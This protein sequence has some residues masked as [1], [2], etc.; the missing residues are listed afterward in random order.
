[1]TGSRRNEIELSSNLEKMLNKENNDHSLDEDMSLAIKANFIKDLS[2]NGKTSVIEF[3]ASSYA[4]LENE[5]VCRLVV[6][7]YGKLDQPVTFRVE[8]IDGTAEAGEDYHKIDEV[9]TFAA[10]QQSLPIDVKIID[11]NQ[12]EPDETFF[13][14]LSIHGDTQRNVKV[15]HKAICMVTIIDD[16]EP[17]EIEF[18]EPVSVIKESSGV[19]EVRLERKNGADG[20]VSVDY[21]TTDINAVSYK[22]YIPK[23]GTIEFKHGEQSK[24][25]P[26][27]IIDDKTAEK[28]ESFSIE[29]FN[30]KG[31]VKLGR[32]AKS[33]ITIIND[34]D[35][36]NINARLANLIN[37]NLDEI[38]YEKKTWPQQFVEAMNVNGGDIETATVTAANFDMFFLCLRFKKF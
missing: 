3:A 22:D 32:F 7:R 38:S 2:D 1:M 4:V 13:V 10:N 30:P 28:D 11:D 26:I 21:K 27:T 20:I 5:Q 9:L 37:A 16:D 33:V 35:L 36:Q 31:G 34:D 19:F 18:I 25:I 15:G 29:L 14:K 8:T 17:G 23:T 24:T 6:E 12:W